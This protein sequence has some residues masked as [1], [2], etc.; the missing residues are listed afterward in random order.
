MRKIQ[1]SA[2]SIL[3]A[4]A[5]S[6][7]TSTASAQGSTK[8]VVGVNKSQQSIRVA[9]VI[10][11]P[12]DSSA[13]TYD[14]GV[15]TLSDKYSGPADDTPERRE[16]IRASK[17]ADIA[18]ALNPRMPNGYSVAATGPDV[19]IEGPDGAVTGLLITRDTTS[20]D[21]RIEPTAFPGGWGFWSLDNS[22]FCSGED[23]NGEPGYVSLTASGI[24]STV[25]TSPGMMG[26][27]VES[28]LFDDLISRG[29]N[30]RWADEADNILTVVDT[31][32]GTAIHLLDTSVSGFAWSVSDAGLMLGS[33]GSLGEPLVVPPPCVGDIADDFG[34][35]GADGMVSF[36]DFLALLGLVGPCP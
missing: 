9:V 4:L 36:G 11:R 23:P 34:S 28:L 29:A 32:D 19:T 1:H 8:L 21:D 12:G 25:Q 18:A 20:E 17:A 16:Q 10:R 33:A 30:I 35:L 13:T 27:D 15:I 31:F 7:A 26:I 2:A 22:S 24:T 14:A 5:V 6:S 3:A